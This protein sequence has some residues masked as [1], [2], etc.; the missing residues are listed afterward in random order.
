[1]EI[2]TNRLRTGQQENKDT[3]DQGNE[4]MRPT[5]NASHF[6]VPE[7]S[8]ISTGAVKL[9]AVR[10]PCGW[11]VPCMYKNKLNGNSSP[12]RVGRVS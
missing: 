3:R 9:T 12:G 1:M 6:I 2:F 5:W 10:K 7:N 4:I 11:A 8:A